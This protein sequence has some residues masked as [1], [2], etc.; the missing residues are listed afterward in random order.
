MSLALPRLAAATARLGRAG[1]GFAKFGIYTVRRFAA[2]GC[3]SAAGAL[4]YTTLVSLVPIIA[5]AF[6]VLSTFPIFASTR[7]QILADLFSRFVPSVG[8]EIE[9][10]FRSFADTAGQTT[11]LGVV[12]LGITVVL[13]LAAI[14]D[15]LD[16]I[17][18]VR[19]PRPWGRRVLIYWAILTLGPL[20]IGVAFSLPA[21]VGHVAARTG[22]NAGALMTAG[23]AQPLLEVLPFV[24]ETAALMLVYR[25]IPNCWVRWYEAGA[26]A[27]VAAVLIDALKRGF[28]LYIG[29]ISTYRAI[30][31][32]L[33]AIPIFL[34]WMYIVWSAVLFGAVVAA[35]LPG[36]AGGAVGRDVAAADPLGLGLAIIDELAVQRR[37]GG[38]LAQVQLAARLGVAPSAIADTLIPLERAGFVVASSDGGWVLARAPDSMTL[39]DFYRALALPLALDLT[40]AAAHADESRVTEPLRRVAALEAAA[41]DRPLSDVLSG[42]GG[43][44]APRAPAQRL[45]S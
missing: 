35:A 16:K 18:R 17:W 21:Y 27:L 2:D 19:S 25:L 36:W 37:Q 23:W 20:L 42:D 13:L 3:P 45:A 6:A 10:W 39:V 11:A 15:Q 38:T 22:L 9:R 44:E 28:V 7:D 4:S 5:I 43:R 31:G 41:L 33:A 30:Y 26:G 24:L 29:T 34:L 32:A 40:A 12:A 8:A 1:S 14:E